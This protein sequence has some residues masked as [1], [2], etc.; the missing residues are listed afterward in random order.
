MLISQSF[1]FLV[2]TYKDKEDEPP[3]TLETSYKRKKLDCCSD[4]CR[5][6]QLC[7]EIWEHKAYRQ[8]V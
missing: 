4:N 3:A 5:V 1:D 6:D 7:D 2:K 8:I